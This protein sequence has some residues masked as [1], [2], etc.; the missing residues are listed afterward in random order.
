MGLLEKFKRDSNQDL[1]EE[2]A[3]DL[4]DKLEATGDKIS[5]KR[6]VFASF[7]AAS[8]LLITIFT[9]V[10]AV[11]YDRVSVDIVFRHVR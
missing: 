11:P 8:L 5:P 2:I 10:I 4:L 3:Y 6:V 1:E 7:V 9:L